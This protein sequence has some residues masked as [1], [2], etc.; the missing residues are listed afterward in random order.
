MSHRDLDKLLAEAK[1]TR[2]PVKDLWPGIESRIAEARGTTSRRGKHALM[3]VFVAAAACILV[4]CG[5]LFAGM[6]VFRPSRSDSALTESMYSQQKL[7]IR[8]IRRAEKNYG[9]AKLKLVKS[10]RALGEIYGE[11]YEAIAREK[12]TDIDNILSEMKEMSADSRMTEFER[13][14]KVFCAYNIQL[15][16]LTGSDNLI[17]SIMYGGGR[18]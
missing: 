7:L 11:G 17:R 10:L 15:D 12:L 8:E 18:E 6:F 1:E 14:F 13:D 3:P 4:L 9:K 16:Y 5:V 2:F